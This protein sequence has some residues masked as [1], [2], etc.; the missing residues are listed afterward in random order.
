VAI[1]KIL[2]EMLSNK[3][4]AGEVVEK[5]AS[6]VKELVEN[7]IDAGSTEI[8]VD[9]LESGIKEIKVTDN[10][11]GMDASDASKCFERYATS[12]ISNED[13]LYRIST[14]GFR[15]EALASIAS[16]SKVTL[17]TGMGDIGTII[18]LSGGKILSTKKG[19]SRKGTIISVRDLFFNTPARLKYL[20][21]LHTELASIVD[22]MNKLA[23][24]KP[25]IRFTLTNDKKHIFSTDG[26]NNLLKTIKAIYGLEVAKKMMPVSECNDDYEIDGYIG[27]PELHRSNRNNIV[28]LVNGRVVRNTELNRWINE[29][30]HSYKPDN[31]YPY[32][33][34]NIIV[35][36]SIVDVNIHPSK[37]DI[38][39]SKQDSL[40]ELV[41]KMIKDKLE[42]KTLIPVVKQK[43]QKEEK[44]TY[45]EISLDFDIVSEPEIIEEIKERMPTLYPI[46][47]VHGTYIVCQ[48]EEGMYLVDQHA[49]KE[50]IDYENIKN[51]LEN[52][53]KEAVTMLLPIT[54]EYSAD[55]YIILKSHFELLSELNFSVEE[56]G[57]NSIVVKEHPVWLPKDKEEENIKNIF[58]MIINL[59]KNFD[60][61]RFYDSLAV[62]VSCSKSIKANTNVSLEE[63]ETLM[64]NL[65]KCENPFN[66]P[67]GRPTIISYTIYEL[68]KM[69]KRS[70]F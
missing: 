18:E 30:Y 21:S 70:G 25:D 49:A 56:F 15:G 28:T 14:L 45:E 67:H 38:K 16:V 50:R 9:L 64:E 65:K 11:K 24:S 59:E 36:T 13:D 7:S 32:V 63:M 40:N 66:C 2:D 53:S 55:E 6:V 5:C 46:G 35:D 42:V 19:N 41:C 58:E 37:M 4:A 8:K 34:L 43:H 47:L 39:F 12:K 3:I 26:S 20:K 31:R 29:G 27:V 60:I 62:A 10:G 23:L 17:E 68:E 51:K 54:I 44:P 52:R 61:V 57:I 1:I 48:N 33:V 22:Y 69:F